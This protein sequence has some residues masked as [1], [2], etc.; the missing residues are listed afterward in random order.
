[1]FS[2]APSAPWRAA[3]PGLLALALLTG[4]AAHAENPAPAPPPPGTARYLIGGDSRNDVNHVIPWAFDQS[5]R[6]GASAFIFLGDME[7]TPELDVKFQKELSLLQPV[8]FYPVLG[9]HEIDQFGVFR[10]GF[11]ERLHGANPEKNFRR[12]FL[13]TKETPVKSNFGDKVVYGTDLPGGL[14]FIALDNV[15]Q[16]GFGDSQLAWLQNDLKAARSNPGTKYIVV[17]MHKA[18]AANGHTTHAMDE[19]GDRSKKDSAVALALFRAFHVNLIFASHLHD[20]VKFSQG[21]IES[22]ITGGLGAPLHI[23]GP[24]SV[25]HVLQLDVSNSGLAVSMIPFDGPT[26]FSD[27]D[28]DDDDDDK[29]PPHGPTPTPVRRVLDWFKH[30]FH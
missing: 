6:R 3:L 21:G 5:K 24:L 20:Y 25:H 28:D 9:N 1:M 7:L 2:N 16:K 13:G 12:R 19:D 4:P 26:L 14:H 30:I 27:D 29:E 11:L 23:A 22:Y 15:S 10:V 17:G 8:P 18:L